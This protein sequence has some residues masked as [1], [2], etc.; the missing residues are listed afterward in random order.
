MRECEDAQRSGV[1]Q[2]A[3]GDV[4]MW[5]CGDVK[6]LRYENVQRSE[7]RQLVDGDVKMRSGVPSVGV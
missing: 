4:K 7:V 2:L 3:D 1:R 5:R 6:M